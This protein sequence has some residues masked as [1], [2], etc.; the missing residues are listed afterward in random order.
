MLRSLA[1]LPLALLLACSEREPASAAPTEPWPAQPAAS[2]GEHRVSYRI[3][4]ESGL[5][6]ELP[7]REATPRGSLP[8]VRGQ[9]EVDLL[10]LE[11][12]RGRLEIDLLAIRMQGEASEGHDAEALAWLD[13]APQREAKRWAVFTIGEVK[14]PGPTA[15]HAG[16][17]QKRAE[18][19]GE[20]RSVLLGASGELELGG[21]R[22]A[23]SIRL[24]AT[25]AYPAPAVPG[26]VPSS[27]RLELTRPLAVAL[28]DHDIK[29]RDA[30]GILVAH[31]LKW[32]GTRVGREAR[33]SG[34]LT[35]SPVTESAAAP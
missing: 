16:K 11:K 14:A 8:R 28:A 31:K 27:I 35:A 32:L 34:W 10:D 5:L 13:L 20:D 17:R 1:A 22:M 21:F 25:F 26:A 18:G 9:L 7:A 30:S 3:E 23:R 6:F 15:A 2:G 19:E 24:R 4:P 29:P 12:S 33:V